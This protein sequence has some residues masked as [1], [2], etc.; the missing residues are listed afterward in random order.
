VATSEVE[1]LKGHTKSV[2]SV[3]F[4]QDGS[5]VVSGSDDETVRT[6]NVMTGKVEAELKGHTKWVRSVAFS[7]DGR[8]VISGSND[9]TIQIWNVMTGKV[10]AKLHGHT[11]S[12]ESSY[13][14]H[15]GPLVMGHPAL[16]M[17]HI[18]WT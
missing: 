1:E 15:V 14:S 5:R 9:K 6:W 13:V 11:N 8:Q 12:V 7:Q 10:E 16:T 4:S 3:T 2:K 17:H 18:V